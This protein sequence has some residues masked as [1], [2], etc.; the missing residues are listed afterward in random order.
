MTSF[1]MET[2]FADG[3]IAFSLSE[4]QPVCVDP[5]LVSH[6]LCALE[7]QCHQFY[8]KLN[9]LALLELHSCNHQ[10]FQLNISAVIDSS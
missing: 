6:P 8:V 3:P 9:T 2:L 10:Y 5:A 7:K 1:I 4:L